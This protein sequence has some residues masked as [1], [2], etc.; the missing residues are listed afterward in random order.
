MFDFDVEEK[1]A[2]ARGRAAR[3][4]TAEAKE[5]RDPAILGIRNGS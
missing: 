5:R 2:R 1:P 4:P 3:R